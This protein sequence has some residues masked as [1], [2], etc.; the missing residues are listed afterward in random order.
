MTAIAA[1]SILMSRFL[2][3]VSVKSTI[4]L[5]TAL[6]LGGAGLTIRA[7][8]LNELI[9]TRILTG[10]GEGVLMAE[11]SAIIAAF[12]DPDR[13]YGRLSA[14]VILICSGIVF[15]LPYC[16]YIYYQELHVFAT[17]LFSFVALSLL[18]LLLN[19]NHQGTRVE[20]SARATTVGSLGLVP[21]GTGVFL[22]GVTSGAM[23][24]FYYLYG[25][26][27]GLSEPEIDTAVGFSTLLSMGGPILAAIIGA[28][29]RRIYH[30]TAGAFILACA[31][32][33]MTLFHNPVA[34]QVCA[35]LII[36]ATYFS[37]S[38]FL[39]YAAALDPSGRGAAVISG[40]FLWT[41]AVGPYLGGLILEHYDGWLM[42]ALAISGNSI[43]WL[44]FVAVERRLQ[45]RDVVLPSD[46]QAMF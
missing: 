26:Q 10:M 32:V 35:I 43:A 41:G 37:L 38:Y 24:P 22:V 2:R 6:A 3:K 21:L 29:P 1:S 16:R 28:A 14:V 8:D 33:G 19:F 11:A 18:L 40:I 27:S 17:M 20:A 39:G 36:A 12:I 30:V 15:S 4:L 5:G 44:L 42:A 23:W 46:R 13:A 7:S 31:I 45:A 34:Y 25:Q 9:I